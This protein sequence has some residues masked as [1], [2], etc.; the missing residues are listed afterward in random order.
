[1]K[2]TRTRLALLTAIA[3]LGTGLALAPA[4]QAA[5]AAAPAASVSPA[6][7]F[8]CNF[9][10]A[11]PTIQFGS[12]GAAV[13]EAQCLLKFWGFGG[14]LGT[15]GPNHDGVDGDFGAKTRAAV[16]AFQTAFCN[17]RVDGIVGTN[18][19]RALRT[20]GC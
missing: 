9:T 15:S 12:T 1:M 6:G 4:A 19:W 11:T 13:R 17:L 7:V 10:D 3:A 14:L 5:P 2:S 20:T 16:R 8:G 18:T